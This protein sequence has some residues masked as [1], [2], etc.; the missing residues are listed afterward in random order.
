MFR[1]LELIIQLPFKII[2][3]PFKIV[4]LLFSTVYNLFGKLL[5]IGLTIIGCFAA[6][7]IG[8][9]IGIILWLYIG[10]NKSLED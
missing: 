3:L 10:S 5:L 2:A 9:P 6:P 4:G 7:P 1:L 8:I